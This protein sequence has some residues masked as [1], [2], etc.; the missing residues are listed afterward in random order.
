MTNLLDDGKCP[1]M[2]TR[3]LFDLLCDNMYP[4]CYDTGDALPRLLNN[5]RYGFAHTY[6]ERGSE[7]AKRYESAYSELALL[8]S[9]HLQVIESAV[10]LCLSEASVSN[11]YEK[12]GEFWYE[13]LLQQDS[14]QYRAP[15]ILIDCREY[16]QTLEYV[17]NIKSFNG[18]DIPI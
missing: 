9:S 12:N 5:L 16:K 18:E 10:R 17:V 6:V 8:P 11:P 4:C 2:V 14:D 13:F 1:L 15:V 7:E 3:S